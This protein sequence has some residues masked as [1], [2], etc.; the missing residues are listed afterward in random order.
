MCDLCY[1]NPHL[2]G[3]PNAPE[4]KHGYKCSYCG[5]EIVEGEYFYDIDGRLY[6]DD[7]LDEMSREKILELVGIDKE[8]A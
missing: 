4:P 1:S 7:C 2:P 6:H 3:C 5:G 8:E